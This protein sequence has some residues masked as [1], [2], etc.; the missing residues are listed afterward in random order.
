M[1][2][3]WCKTIPTKVLIIGDTHINSL[4]Q[5]PKEILYEIDKNEWLIHVGDFVSKKLVDQLIELK[6]DKFKGVYGN[7]DPLQIR[8][9]LPAKDIIVINGKKIGII[10][11]AKGGIYDN[12]KKKVFLE[13]KNESVDVIIYGHTHDPMIETFKDILFI[14]PGKGYVE[15]QYFGPAASF[16]ILIIDETIKAEIRE[17]SN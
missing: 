1:N 5:L 2:I 16:A 3:S 10:H 4:D 6:K 7:T 15:E 8:Q 11:P 14:N 9:A 13:F 17:I 12:T